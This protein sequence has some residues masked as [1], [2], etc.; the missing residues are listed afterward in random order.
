MNKREFNKAQ[1]QKRKNINKL[2]LL[3]ITIIIIVFIVFTTNAIIRLVQNPSNTVFVKEGKVSKEETDTGIIIRDETVIK[4][5]NYKNGMEQIVDEGKRVAKDEPIFRYYS[6]GEDGIKENI[7]TLDL[8]IQEAIENNNDD[9]FSSDTK[10]LDTQISEKLEEISNLNTVQIIQEYKKSLDTMISKKAKIAGELSPSGSYLKKLI[11]QRTTYEK[12]LNEGSEY[13]KSTI[14]GM[15]S[16]RIDG[17]EET[18]TTSDFSKYTEEFLD[19]LNI[20]TGQIIQTNSEKG[21]IINNFICYIACTSKSAEANNAN[22]GDK[23]KIQ[24]PSGRNVDG[25]IVYITKENDGGNTLIISFN[26]GI[27]ELSTYRKINF[28]IIW[29]DSTG[30]KVPNS[31]IITENDL[32]Y[33]IRTKN[34]YYDKVLVKVKKK[35]DNYSI[36]N[37]YSTSEIKDLNVDKTISTTLKLYDELILKPTDEQINNA[38]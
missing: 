11:D 6:S 17:L 18:L 33:V 36:V 15:V 22:V 25:K 13:V 26:E 8:K 30:Y 19:S 38:K 7:K 24:L 3:V 31:A 29:W 4:G 9:L 5:E 2:K 16:Y 1:K 23:I 27:D 10:L 12:Q 35:S 20:K 14:S 28:D 32:N 37:N 21:K 34:G